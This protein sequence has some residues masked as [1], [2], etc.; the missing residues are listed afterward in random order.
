MA[1]AACNSSF[2]VGGSNLETADQITTKVA[3][4]LLGRAKVA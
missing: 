4:A 2:K 3:V 1:S